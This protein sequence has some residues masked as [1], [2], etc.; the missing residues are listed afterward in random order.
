MSRPLASTL[1]LFFDKLKRPQT[2][3]HYIAR[4]IINTVAF[5]VCILSGL[6]HICKCA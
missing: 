6:L 2:I 3:L 1:T 4:D 5:E